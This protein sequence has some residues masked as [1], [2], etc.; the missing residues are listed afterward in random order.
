VRDAVIDAVVDRAS[1]LEGIAVA[2]LLETVGNE[3]VDHDLFHGAALS[4]DGRGLVLCGESGFGKSLL[5]LSLLRRGWRFLSDEVACVSHA[6]GAL[7]AFPKALE[8][9]PETPALVGV[10]VG[11]PGPR[12]KAIVDAET[13]F[14][15]CISDACPASAVVFLEDPDPRGGPSRESDGALRVALHRR[16]EG[17]TEAVARLDGVTRAFWDEDRA[18]YPV[19]AIVNEP[20]RFAAWRLDEVLGE[21]GALIVDSSAEAVAPTDFDREPQLEAMERHAG[22]G[23]LLTRFRGRRAFARRLEAQGSFADLFL[24]LLERFAGTRFYSLSVGRLDPT[25]ALLAGTTR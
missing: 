1:W 19:L 23:R 24:S 14:P 18:G 12:G 20:G 2:R 6:S 17:L 15:G 11:A 25:L 5:T 4:L 7:V 21:R 13:L 3:V 16:A 10:E 9:R 8:L 22:V